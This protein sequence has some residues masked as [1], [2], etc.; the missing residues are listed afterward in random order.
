MS[1]LLRQQINEL[2]EGAERD[3]GTQTP[4]APRRPEPLGNQID[5]WLAK[6]PPALVARPWSMAELQM[7]FV[8]K[9]RQRPHAQSVATELRKRGWYTHRTWTQPGYGQRLWFAPIA[10]LYLGD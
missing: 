3:K 2:I 7:L 1:G 8:G 6:T 4:T 5:R 10:S 9:Y